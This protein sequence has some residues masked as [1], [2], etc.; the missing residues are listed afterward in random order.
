ML[1]VSEAE[2]QV[3]GQRPE[4][5]SGS[6]GFTV[7]IIKSSATG[8][9]YVGHTDDLQRRLS[10]HNSREHNSAKY[11]SKN[12]GPWDLIYREGHSSRSEA[13]KRERWL[14]SGIGRHWIDE[15]F[16]RASPLLAD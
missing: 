10:E 4:P 11:T 14:K 12:A 7:Y 1:S 3:Q 5:Y 2:R 6:L 16:G 15:K 9:R 13:M 8:K